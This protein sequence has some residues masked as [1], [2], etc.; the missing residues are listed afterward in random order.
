MSMPLLEPP[1]N[2]PLT[3]PAAG[4]RK[5]PAAAPGPGEA[6]TLADLVEAPL[7]AAAERVGALRFAW[8]CALR[9]AAVDGADDALDEEEA[10]SARVVDEVDGGDAVRVLDVSLGDVP[11]ATTRAQSIAPRPSRPSRPINDPRAEG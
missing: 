4:H 11:H 10:P 9:L 8:R 5:V 2:R 7:P 1:L 3:C 6:V